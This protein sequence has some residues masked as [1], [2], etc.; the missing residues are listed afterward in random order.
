[1]VKWKAQQ[2]HFG[3]LAAAMAP[4]W[5][6]FDRQSNFCICSIQLELDYF[7]AEHYLRAL[8]KLKTNNAYNEVNL[9]VLNII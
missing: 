3:D 1:M 4:I 2:R 7:L 6:F 5:R 8:E 9:Q